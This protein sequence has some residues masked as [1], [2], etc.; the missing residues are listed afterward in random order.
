M[1]IY[2]FECNDS[3]QGE[4][5]ERNLLGSNKPWPTRVKRGDFCLLY[6]YSRGSEH[7]IY[8][9]YKATCDGAPKLVSEAWGI[10]SSNLC[11]IFEVGKIGANLP[12][13]I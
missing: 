5:L 4:C 3:T 13:W 12:N 11:E 10:V 1:H 8:G 6:N 9:I 2:V 7:M